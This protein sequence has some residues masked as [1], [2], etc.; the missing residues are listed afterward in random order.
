MEIKMII[1]LANVPYNPSRDIDKILDTKAGTAIYVYAFLRG[2]FGEQV[3]MDYIESKIDYF[4]GKCGIDL[5]KVYGFLY[6]AKS[7][8]DFVDLLSRES[9]PAYYEDE[10]GGGE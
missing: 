2:K 3:D 6:T 5:S 4:C 10:D 8:G 1:D 9:H 7:V